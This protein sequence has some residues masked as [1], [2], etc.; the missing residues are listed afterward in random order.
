MT[1]Q[2]EQ[3]NTSP[4]TTFEEFIH[5]ANYSLINNL[6]ADP[7]SS[8]DVNDHHAR[9]VYSGHFVPVTPTPLEN[10]EYVTHSK[11]FFK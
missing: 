3:S 10:P 7:E 9:Q 2:A 1:R 4:I 8:V 11:S 6:N 5:L